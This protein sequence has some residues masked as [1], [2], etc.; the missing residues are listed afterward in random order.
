MN[1]L[2]L[3]FCLLALQ[4]S[5]AKLLT[6]GGPPKCER[7]YISNGNEDYLAITERFYPERQSDDPTILIPPCTW[8]EGCRAVIPLNATDN[9]NDAEKGVR[10]M[11]DDDVV[12]WLPGH[13]S[14]GSMVGP[15]E[16]VYVG[17]CGALEGQTLGLGGHAT[18]RRWG[19]QYAT[20]LDAGRWAWA[21]GTNPS[22]PSVSCAATGKLQTTR[23]QTTGTKSVSSKRS[24]GSS[25]AGT[26][27]S[28]Q[29][30]KSVSSTK[31]GTIFSKPLFGRKGDDQTQE[32]PKK[33]SQSYTFITGFPFP[34]GPVFKR[35]TVRTEVEKDTIWVFE[36][37]QALEFVDVYTPLRMTVIKLKSGGLWVHAPCAPTKE[38]IDLV[39]ELDA[40]VE[41]I[42]LPTFAYEH[43]AFVG[44]FSRAFPK[45]KVYVGPDQWSFPVNFPN[46]FFG[47]FGAQVLKRTVAGDPDPIPWSD[48]IEYQQFKLKFKST[49]SADFVR[50]GETAFFHKKTR[51]LLFTDAVVYIPREP[52]RVVPKQALVALGKDNWLCRYRNGGRTSQETRVIGATQPDEDTPET[53]TRV[54][55]LVYNKFP[56]PTNAK[57]LKNAFYFAYELTDGSADAEVVGGVTTGASPTGFGGFF[58]NLLSGFLPAAIVLQKPMKIVEFP[59]NDVGTLRDLDKILRQIGIIKG[60]KDKILRKVG[61]STGESDQPK[62]A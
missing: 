10:A 19:R 44:P 56:T 32:Y 43:K 7:S 51:T 23:S 35:N 48:E 46:E 41:A 40:P 61:I 42:V 17:P 36:Q 24:T 18:I 3:I 58:S 14:S 37:T 50:N 54:Q 11:F 22:T 5:S 1:L 6:Q 62:E 28:A 33:P 21:L 55:E 39:K 16:S 57:D 20:I 2:M 31:S 4:A 8:A 47:I 15:G 45:A 34:L 13:F 30:K 59:E 9:A 52:A 38:C 25:A 27:K 29:A 12:L 26:V 49:V 60:E 53:R